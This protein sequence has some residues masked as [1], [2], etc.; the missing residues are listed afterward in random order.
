[1]KEFYVYAY[2]RTD[3]SPYYIGKGKGNR[4]Y[5]QHLSHIRVPKDKNRIKILYETI[6]ENDAWNKEKELIFIY[7]RKD[8]GTGILRN[9]T[10]GG[11]G[12]T[13]RILSEEHKRKI[14]QSNSISLKG[15]TPW[16]KGK[17]GTITP[18]HKEK[19]VEALRKKG[20]WNKGKSKISKE[21][22][23]EIKIK[24]LHGV[25]LKVLSEEYKISQGHLCILIKNS[26]DRPAI[27]P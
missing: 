4:A 3:G 11:E 9:L 14:G 18:E 5:N 17:T 7:G 10:D 19:M 6:D 15:N 1:M 12:A 22:V 2:L 24:R 26:S 25:T 21:L 8:K 13:G 23:E 27:K 20:P 16:N